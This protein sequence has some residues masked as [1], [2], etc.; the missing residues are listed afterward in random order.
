MTPED[1]T[2]DVTQDGVVTIVCPHPRCVWDTEIVREGDVYSERHSTL[3]W[4][5]DLARDHLDDKDAN[6]TV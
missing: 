1:F 5:L 2:I 6:H 3:R 4:A